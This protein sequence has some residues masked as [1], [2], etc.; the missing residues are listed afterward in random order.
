M[1]DEANFGEGEPRALPTNIHD[2]LKM[3]RARLLS[4]VDEFMRCPTYIA[5]EAVKTM[6]RVYNFAWCQD[7]AA[8]GRESVPEKCK[9]EDL[10]P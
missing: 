3:T 2:S 9:H 4:A 1:G 6:L 5:C 10:D 8:R 7:R